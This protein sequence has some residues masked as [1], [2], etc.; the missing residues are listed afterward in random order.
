MIGRRAGLLAAAGLATLQAVPGRAQPVPGRVARV[1]I[2]RPSAPPA[3]PNDP[4]AIGFIRALEELGHVQ[5]RNLQVEARWG[6]GDP[7]RLPALA[8]E[9]VEARTDVV[10]A[11]ASSSIQA[12][13]A[14]SPTQ[15]VV[16]FGN[17][18]PVAMGFVPNLARPGGRVT[19]ILIAPD[20]T[21][22]AKKL[23]LLRAS[24]PGATRFGYLSQPLEPSSRLQQQELE[25]A[26]R[27]LGVQ[28]VTVEV[29]GNDYA[30]AFA[31][32]GAL[33]PGGVV[34]GANNIFMIHRKDI[35]AQ[36]ARHR[37]PAIYEWR[38]Q[39]MDGGLMTYA[40]NL[41]GLYQRVAVYVD[42]ILKG[43]SPGDLPIERPSKIDFVVNLRTARAL[44]LEL[45]Q[46]LLL[47]ADEVI[48]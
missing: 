22:G 3:D 28:L 35:I 23:E 46:S 31:D 30:R 12:V 9:L 48:E 27:S 7:K 25:Q 41:N 19:G 1:G 37:L 21:L 39:V 2:L 8:R 24:V 40:P 42:R 34:V 45:P 15:R 47:R 17:F 33:K 5:G 18:D 14:A 11:V 16:M 13:L 4:A 29:K 36:A 20:G 6:H 32:L 44:G 26:A 10:I 43:A 38:E